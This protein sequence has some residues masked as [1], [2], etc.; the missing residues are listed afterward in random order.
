M[1]AEVLL[2][3]GMLCL[4]IVGAFFLYRSTRPTGVVAMVGGVLIVGGA[5]ALFVVS[6]PPWWSTVAGA[7]AGLVVVALIAPRLRPARR[8]A[9]R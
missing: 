7:L 2:W 4:T 9:A 5:V 1:A 3:I 6:S 8:Y